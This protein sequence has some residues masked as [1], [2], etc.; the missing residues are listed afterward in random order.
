MTVMFVDHVVLWVL[1]LTKNLKDPICTQSSSV[2]HFTGE[3]CVNKGSGFHLIDECRLQSSSITAESTCNIRCF[4]KKSSYE[5]SV[6][7]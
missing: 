6:I 7:Y 2:F 4:C 5:C 1:S 3:Y